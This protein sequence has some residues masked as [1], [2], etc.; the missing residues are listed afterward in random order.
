[1]YIQ[2]IRSL[3]LTN[4]GFR[5]TIFKNTFWLAFA[6]AVTRLLKLGLI[7]YVARILG[8]HGYGTFT[9]ALSFV[10][11]FVVFS[12]F[13]L[14]PISTREFSSGKEHDFSSV[15]SLKIVLSIAVPI[16]IFIGS[17]FITHDIIA[18]KAIWILAIF[19][20]G[21]NF[22]EILYALIR[23]RQK[24]EYEAGIKIFQAVLLTAIGI[25][26]IIKF[27]SVLNLSYAYF[28]AGI[29]SLIA[30]L[31][32]FHKFIFPLRFSITPVVW[33]KFLYM[34]WPLGL[35]G[36]FGAVNQNF[37]SLILGYLDRL[38]ETGWYNAAWKIA[39]ICLLPSI[40]LSQSFFPNLSHAYK[41]SKKKFQQVWN[42]YTQTVIVL[43]VP[44]V[45]GGVVLAARIINFVYTPEFMP[46]IL[47]LQILIPAVGMAFI[48][49]SFGQTL[50][51]SH[52]QK[53]LFIIAGLGATVNV[54][55]NILLVPRL[56][57]YGGALAFLLAIVFSLVLA[58]KFILTY[59]TIKP[60]NRYIILNILLAVLSS[61]VM[62]FIISLPQVYYHNIFLVVIIGALS[63]FASLFIFKKIV[64][65]FKNARM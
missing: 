40:L 44:L 33:K 48:V 23:A 38:T 20:I 1:M 16:I 61:I 34:A 30:I 18:R 62:Y 49:S 36:I 37:A 17:F 46:S 55:L 63:Y 2:K 5:Q 12:D 42:F 3:L 51:A 10:S 9:F 57:P 19:I 59:T 21:Y 39:S 24:M 35:A 31:I 32:F 22:G 27:P 56:G 28:L 43:A 41:Q 54:I 65:F 53:K 7:I 13:G 6:E 45:V 64:S 60:F 58:Y 14:S 47:V 52:H 11:L 15:F 8:V 26:I 50:L 4:L 29:I 25:F